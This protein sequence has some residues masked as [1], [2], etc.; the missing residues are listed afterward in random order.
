[1]NKI[2]TVIYT[3]RFILKKEV[4]LDESYDEYDQD[5]V[6]ELERLKR[7]HKES[8]LNQVDFNKYDFYYI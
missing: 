8:L 7:Q 1:M 5:S 6:E 3:V 2:I 4:Q